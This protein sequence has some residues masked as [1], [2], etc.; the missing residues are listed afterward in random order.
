MLQTSTDSNNQFLNNNLPNNKV[1][2]CIK[3]KNDKYNKFPYFNS[4]IF[5]KDRKIISP[6]INVTE[7][8]SYFNE[9][10]FN[11]FFKS[12]RHIN[13]INISDETLNKTCDYSTRSLSDRI[14]INQTLRKISDLNYEKNNKNYPYV[15][16]EKIA[17]KEKTKSLGY[18]KTKPNEFQ[19]NYKQNSN[20]KSM[21]EFTSLPKFKSI[22]SDTK[23]HDIKK[24]NDWG[25]I[26]N[27]RLND[28][29][30][31]N[32]KTNNYIK[33][34]I[35][36]NNNYSLEKNKYSKYYSLSINNETKNQKKENHTFVSNS[37][38]KLEKVNE[39]KKIKEMRVL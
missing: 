39:R 19:S 28:I 32:E 6:I 34:I 11:N 31:R 27:K 8:K 37:E 17:E 13:Q 25:K 16:P 12:I 7:L 26:F 20:R 15:K 5:D 38:I 4:P 22:N 36:T 21:S 30:K 23:K 10:Y 2:H 24:N 14:G 3:Y 35:Y 1:L 29:I 18:T 9:K 33:H